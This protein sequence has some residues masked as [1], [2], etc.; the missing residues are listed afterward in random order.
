MEVG[1]LGV[2]LGLAET[3]N[4]DIAEQRQPPA[5]AKNIVRSSPPD[6]G[7]DPMPRRGRH[8]EVELFAEVLPRFE[9]GGLD[10]NVGE[11]RYP[12]TSTVCEGLSGLDCRDGAPER[13]ERSGR[14]AGSATHFKDRT[15]LANPCNPYEILEEFVGVRRANPA[16]RDAHLRAA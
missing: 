11:R 16:S 13:G 14:L 6:F 7:V 10:G 8:D 12:L 5:G 2:D 15:L 3:A 1:G 9:R 4:D